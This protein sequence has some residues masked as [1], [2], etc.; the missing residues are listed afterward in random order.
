MNEEKIL[1]KFIDVCKEIRRQRK[2]VY[3]LL[4]NMHLYLR[5][6]NGIIDDFLPFR[7]TIK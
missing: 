4:T 6:S 5:L 1:I 2:M 3:F 7:E